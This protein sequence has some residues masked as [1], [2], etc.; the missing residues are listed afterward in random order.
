MKVSYVKRIIVK[1]ATCK[2]RGVIRER[3]HMFQLQS[4]S[5]EVPRRDLYVE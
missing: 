2:V 5:G 1:R 4:P 3:V